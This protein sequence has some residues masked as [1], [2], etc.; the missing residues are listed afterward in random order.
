VIGRPR[1]GCPR[2]A[3]LPPGVTV[4]KLPVV[5]RTWYERGFG[6]WARRAGAVLLLCVAVAVYATIIAGVVLAAG[7]PGS[8]GFL[9]VLV[10]EVAFSL[11]SGVFAFRHLRG[12]GRSGRATR[13]NR[14]AGAAGA[15]A[16]LTAFWLG[17]VGAFLLVVSVLLSS[18]F[19]LAALAIWLTPVP[20]AERRARELL[21]DQ[22]GPDRHLRH[23][24]GQ[25]GGH[26]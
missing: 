25:H 7:R 23:L 19:V 13:G 3:E 11:V 9:A 17:G 6:Y 4:R 16:G 26:Q 12:L 15:G 1:A 10:A 24:P 20:P 5:G 14:S 21:A 18:G 22:L 8:A 2:R